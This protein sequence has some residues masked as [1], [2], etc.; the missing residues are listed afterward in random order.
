LPLKHLLIGLNQLLVFHIGF[1]YRF[2]NYLQTSRD[3]GEPI[4]PHLIISFNAPPTG[5]PITGWLRFLNGNARCFYV[6]PV[7]PANNNVYLYEF[8]IFRV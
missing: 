1:I 4:R 2:L 6:F 8:L 3:T 5:F 7:N